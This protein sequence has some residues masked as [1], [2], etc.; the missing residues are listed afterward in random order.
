MFDWLSHPSNFFWLAIAAMC[1]V[2]AALHYMRQMKLDEQ[3]AQLK[4]D[5]I[6]R[7]MSPEDIERVLA[8]KQ[9]GGGCGE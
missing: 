7:G 5:M 2:P 1:I 6:A 4:R 9:G 8:A 3:Q